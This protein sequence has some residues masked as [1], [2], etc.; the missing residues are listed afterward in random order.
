MAYSTAEKQSDYHRKYYLEHRDVMLEKMG[1]WRKKNKAKHL[2]GARAYHHKHKARLAE[3]K[4]KHRKENPEV[5][6][7]RMRLK[8]YGMSGGEF[9]AL[10]AKQGGCCASCGKERLLVVDH[11]HATNAVRA[12]LCSPCNT[13]IGLLKEDTDLIWRAMEYVVFHKRAA[14]PPGVGL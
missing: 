14:A 1:E 13:A 8:K 12:L 3:L 2:A 7:D 4:R 6:A 10:A 11:C 5:Y 9:R